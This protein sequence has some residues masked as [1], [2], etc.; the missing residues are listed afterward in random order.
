VTASDASG[1]DRERT[2][3]RVF[4]KTTVGKKVAMGVTGAALALFVI[5]HVLGNLLVFRGRSELNRYS[6]L[7][8]ASSELLWSVRA[9]PVIPL[10][11]LL[12]IV[13]WGAGGSRIKTYGSATTPLH[14]ALAARSKWYVPNA[15]TC[16]CASGETRGSSS[17]ATTS[18]RASSCATI[19]AM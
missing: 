4:L 15:V 10:G 12:R 9:V 17:L 6:S 1:M 18:P 13:R 2:R 3:R 19:F 8:H 7:L 16:P 11:V 14:R 5:G